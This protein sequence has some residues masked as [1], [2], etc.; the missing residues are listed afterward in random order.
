VSEILPVSQLE[1][2]LQAAR[3]LRV[4]VVG[5]FTLDGYWI[6]DMTRSQLSRETPLFPR[7]VVEERYSCGGAA[8]VAWNLAALGLAEVRAFTVLGADWRGDLLRGALAQAGVLTQD[9]ISEPGWKTPFF[10]KV[11]LSAGPLRQEDARLDFIN[12][13]VLS[14]E[15]EAGLLERLEDALPSLDAVVV[16]DYQPSGVITPRVLDGLNGLARQ[17][18]GTLF[19][20]DSR[21]RIGHFLGMVRKP[22]QA[23][24]ASWLFPERAPGL[25]S[26]EEFAEAAL[27][28][29]VDCGCPLFITLGAQGCLVL[30]NGESHIVPAV[31]VLPPVDPV[32]AGDSFLSALT[33]ALAAGANPLAA[34]R[35]GHL[36]SAV[37]VQKLGI[38]GAASPAEIIEQARQS[39]SLGA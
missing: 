7:P 30:A 9:S 18:T 5:D 22:N 33:A 36:A 37:T 31:P 15:S 28:P 1:E 13:T 35:M 25:V 34:A 24:A 8:N 16:A 23:E 10:G 11:I 2:V 19:T 6:A 21:E 29:Q 26:V 32:G 14:V 38:T 39:T 27:H 4:A 3:G 17:F 20:V 12:T